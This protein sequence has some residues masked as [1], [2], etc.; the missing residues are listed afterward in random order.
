MEALCRLAPRGGHPEA[1]HPFIRERDDVVGIGVVANSN[2]SGIAKSLRA[3][4]LDVE[5]GRCRHLFCPLECG[6][7]E[8]VAKAMDRIAE[9]MILVFLS[10]ALCTFALIF[11][12]PF[13]APS[14][15]RWLLAL[16]SY[17]DVPPDDAAAS[18]GRW[19]FSCLLLYRPPF[20][21]Q[22]SC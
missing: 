2:F 11:D 6:E 18:K 15:Q 20:A 19:S 1:V 5:S 9:L 12:R 4:R 10:G 17:F 3:S 22:H 13:V 7:R 16:S 8:E 14:L 21:R